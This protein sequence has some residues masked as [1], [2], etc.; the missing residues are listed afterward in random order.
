[1]STFLSRAA[2]IGALRGRIETISSFINEAALLTISVQSLASDITKSGLRMNEI[3]CQLMHA[4][5]LIDGA[6]LMLD[7]E[8]NRVAEIYGSYEKKV[9]R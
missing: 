6:K 1:M 8:L 4:T 5:K 7:Q 9:R 3:R 2:D